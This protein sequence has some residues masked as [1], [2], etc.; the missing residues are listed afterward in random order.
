MEEDFR[1]TNFFVAS[2]PPPP[3]PPWHPMGALAAWDQGHHPVHIPSTT[4]PRRLPAAEERAIAPH[5]CSS[6]RWRMQAA[7]R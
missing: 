6:P 5:V 1:Y 3:R 4:P 2:G 7:M